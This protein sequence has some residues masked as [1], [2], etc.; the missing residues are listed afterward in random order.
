M[1]TRIFSNV[2]IVLDAMGAERGRRLLQK[3]NRP[4][5][6]SPPSFVPLTPFVRIDIKDGEKR[7]RR[8]RIIRIVPLTPFVRIDIKDGGKRVRRHRIIRIVYIYLRSFYISL[9]V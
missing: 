6:L 1:Y 4:P 2:C 7:V 5:L 9:C 8:H 3:P